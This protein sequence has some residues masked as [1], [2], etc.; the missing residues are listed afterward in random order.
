VRPL[1]PRIAVDGITKRF[2]GVTAN[3][4]VSF[5]ALPGEIHA[6]LGENGSGKTTLCKIMTGL[7][8][9]DAGTVQVDGV[10]VQ[11]TSPAAA[12]A[13][14]IFMVPQ[15]LS[16]VNRLTVA[17]NLA[18]GWSGDAR[19]RRFNRESAER[20]AAEAAS[21]LGTSVKP[22]ALVADLALGER[23]RVEMLRALQRGARTLILDEPTT[24]LTPQEVGQ[25]FITLRELARNGTTIIFISHKLGE[26]MEVCQ[27]VTVIRH[28]RVR[29]TVGL[30]DGKVDAQGLARMMVDREVEVGRSRA[31]RAGRSEGRVLEVDEI[32]ARG[33]DGRVA[34]DGVSF[35][36]DRGEILGVAGVAGNGQLELA[37]VIAGLTPRVG[38]SVR[39]GGKEIPKGDPLGAIRHGIAYVPGDR[40][41][42][43]LV[44]EMN[45]AENMVLKAYRAAPYSKGPLLVRSASRA[46]AAELVERFDI[47]GT[48]QTLVRQLSGGNAQKVL[49]ARELS[50]QPTVLVISSPTAGLDVA[51]SSATR[52]LILDAAA[53]GVGVLLL[54]ED[55]DEVMELSD[56]IA[57]MYHGRI[58]GIC[59][60]STAKVGELGRL[61]AGV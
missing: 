18:L 47:R 17:E 11:L 59:E 13:L 46:M 38:G 36:V 6:L 3:D 53:D 34:V 7:L 44:P 33:S 15:H 22:K 41:R 54:S 8:R 5:G 49:L 51:A 4:S 57:V 52:R 43:G 37:E 58:A 60:G 26:I 32:T 10:D 30:E 31:R 9:P 28:G 25:L 2:P 12:H 45:V 19:R 55:L 61:M 29:G 14:G 42:V 56:R 23:Q 48:P 39:V 40:R 16:L 20:D 21:R 35:S 27:R 1:V 24:V 50:S